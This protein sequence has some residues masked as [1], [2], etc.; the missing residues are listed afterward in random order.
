MSSSKKRPILNANINA[1]PVDKKDKDKD[2]DGHNVDTDN[3]V[4]DKSSSKDKDKE[5]SS[6]VTKLNHLLHSL[7][8]PARDYS[9][10]RSVGM[11]TFSTVYMAKREKEKDDKG[12]D[13]SKAPSA[14]AFPPLV[15]IKHLIPTSSPDRI[16]MELEC[17]RLAG[18]KDNIIPLLF[19]DRHVGDIVLGMPFVNTNKFADVMPTLTLNQCLI[20]MKNLLLALVGEVG[21]GAI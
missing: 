15:A 12:N 21:E 18:G 8:S 3:K 11:G 6:A 2:K 7:S 4:K 14:S 10:L 9:V 19:V 16:L 17:L 5:E 1:T 13:N 20:Y